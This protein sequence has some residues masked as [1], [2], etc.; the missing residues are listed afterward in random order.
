[1]SD[2]GSRLRE[3]IDHTGLTQKRFAESVELNQSHLSAIINGSKELSGATVEKI[4]EQYCEEYNIGWLLT[5]RG[6]MFLSE[7]NQ[8][9][10]S[11]P[12]KELRVSEIQTRLF[13]LENKVEKIEKQ[14][15]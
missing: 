14:L 9:R 6:P 12:D 3:I 2:K 8:T 5:G 4:A 1:M 7:T 10:I 15:K 13:Q 11:Q